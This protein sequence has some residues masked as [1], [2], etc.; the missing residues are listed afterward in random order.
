MS[1]IF[2]TDENGS[3]EEGFDVYLY[4][5]GSDEAQSDGSDELERG[6]PQLREAIARAD[7][8][9][10]SGEWA[11]AIVGEGE[12]VYE[13]YDTGETATVVAGYGAS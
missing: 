1:E 13:H 6:Y 12:S 3:D 5:D 8:A 4:R 11:R 2:D 7:A 9:I 10:A